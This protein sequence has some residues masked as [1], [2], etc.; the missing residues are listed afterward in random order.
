MVNNHWAKYKIEKSF[1]KPSLF[2]AKLENISD[3]DQALAIKGVT[4]GVPR[5]KFPQLAQ[6]EYYWTDLI[7]K[8]VYNLDKQLLGNVT[9]LMDTGANSVLVIKHEDQQQRL[10]PFVGKYVID[11]DVKNEQIIVDWGLDWWWVFFAMQ[12]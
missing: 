6:D 12:Q 1:T 11:V 5:D 10:I 7:G 4:V 2:H 9:S 8:K 3:R